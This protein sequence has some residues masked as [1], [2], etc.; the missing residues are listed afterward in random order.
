MYVVKWTNNARV[1][2]PQAI[3]PLLEPKRRR[4]VDLTLIR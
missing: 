1:R 4:V 3:V 2:I